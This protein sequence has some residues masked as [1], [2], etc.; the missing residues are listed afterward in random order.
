MRPAFHFV[1]D[2]GWINDPH[3]ITVKDGKY[4]LFYQYVPDS[5][6]WAPNCHWGHAEGSDLFSLEQ[7]PVAIAPGDGDEGIWT[8]SLVTDDN[9]K[10]RIFYTSTSR[11][12]IGIGR[13]RVA[14][15]VDESWIE[16]TKGDFVADVPDGLDIIAYRDPFLVKEATGWRMFVGAGSSDGTAMAL[17]YTSADLEAWEYE[18]IAL[19]RSTNERE[20]VWLGALWECPQIFDVDGLHLMVSS[21]WDD[22]VLHYAGYAMGGYADG[23]F[24]AESWGRL[25]YGPS[26]YAPSFFRDAQGRPCLTFWMRGIADQDAGWASAHSVPHVLTVENNRLISTPHPDLEK[27][28]A[29]VVNDGNLPALAGDVVWSPSSGESLRVTSAGKTV[30]VLDADSQKLIA[31]SETETLEVP[32]LGGDVRII[33]DAQAIEVSSTGGMLGFAAAPEGPT[34]SVE[35]RH[36]TVYLLDRQG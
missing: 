18:G 23:Q 14:S 24:E 10:T 22:D 1:A 15:P 21:V 32:Y 5:T 33:L 8:G 16:W 9:G 35:A 12:N 30:F 19:Q 7:L 6:T 34:Y 25:T 26:Y 28:R 20:P 31:T 2:S 17:S 13:I 4:H 36:A 3:G 27:Y 11:P 29:P